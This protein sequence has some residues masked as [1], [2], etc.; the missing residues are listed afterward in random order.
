MCPIL[1]KLLI[2]LS[3]SVRILG[4]PTD[5]QII[6]ESMPLNPNSFFSND[7]FDAI[8]DCHPIHLHLVAKFASKFAWKMLHMLFN[9]SISLFRCRNMQLLYK[10]S[11]AFGCDC[12]LFISM[13]F[14]MVECDG[15]RFVVEFAEFQVNHR[16]QIDR[17]QIFAHSNCFLFINFRSVSKSSKSSERKRLILYILY[18]LL[19]PCVL[20]AFKLASKMLESAKG[21]RIHS[22]EMTFSRINLQFV[23]FCT[24]SPEQAEDLMRAVFIG[25]TFTINIVF[26]ILTTLKIREVRNEMDQLT[27]QEDSSR[28]HKKMNIARGK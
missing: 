25:I 19:S 9:L 13:Q 24:V 6:F 26:F 28:H 14:S 2:K 7:H 22:Y 1:M 15:L 23:W 21:I 17:I 5:F 27:S 10:W 12:R 16:E 8:P 3:I 11:E 20:Y 18:A 4:F